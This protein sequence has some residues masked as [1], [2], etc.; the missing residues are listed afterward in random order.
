MYQPYLFFFLDRS[1]ENE[2]YSLANQLRDFQSQAHQKA[3][4]AEQSF[5]SQEFRL[6]QEIAALQSKYDQA[7]AA[8]RQVAAE[9][10]E[11]IRRRQEL[12]AQ[13]DQTRK[14]YRTEIDQMVRKYESEK[15]TLS[16]ELTQAKSAVEELLAS[17][18]PRMKEKLRG[19]EERV[20]VLEKELSVIENQLLSV[21][22]SLRQ[23]VE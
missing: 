15:A 21:I 20:R 17:H 3:M 19:A 7:Q 16:T 10:Q 22:Q 13:L 11:F 18:D 1:K 5:K 4:A 2:A 12:E 23:E 14:D 9:S 8:S 6:G